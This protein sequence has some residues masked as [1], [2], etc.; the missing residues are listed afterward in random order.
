[1]YEAQ[2]VK[3]F[4]EYLINGPLPTGYS[5][6][7]RDWVSEVLIGLAPNTRAPFVPQ[8][9]S[10]GDTKTVWDRL[11]QNIGSDSKLDGLVIAEKKMNDRKN[12][13]F[14]RAH[15]D[16]QNGSSEAKTRNTHRAVSIPGHRSRQQFRESQC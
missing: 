14:K 9:S 13:F 12:Q 10:W 11:F 4:L 16:P 2:T 5:T 3:L 1:M 15:L 8:G 7:S 6:A